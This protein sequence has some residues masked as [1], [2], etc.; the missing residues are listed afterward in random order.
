MLLLRPEDLVLIVRTTADVRRP[1][2][3]QIRLPQAKN[4]EVS[5]TGPPVLTIPVTLGPCHAATHPRF[6]PAAL[7]ASR[8][9]PSRERQPAQVPAC[10][11]HG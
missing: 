8:R 11:R 4:P 5:A 9:E 1:I 7:P 3:A 6:L 10:V 2:S